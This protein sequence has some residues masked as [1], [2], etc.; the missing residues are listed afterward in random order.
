MGAPQVIRAQ[1]SCPNTASRQVD[2]MVQIRQSMARHLRLV[3]SNLYGKG[4][5]RC[6]GLMGRG[7]GM[8]TEHALEQNTDKHGWD[9]RLAREDQTE[10]EIFESLGGIT[11]RTGT[12]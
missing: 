10:F 2:C 11:D 6:F 3:P 1:L 7:I 12:R 9:R 8:S 4:I 5:G